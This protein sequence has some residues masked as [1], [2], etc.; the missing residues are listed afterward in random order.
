MLAALRHPSIAPWDLQHAYWGCFV[1]IRWVR[2][3]VIALSC[4]WIPK[5]HNER[6]DPILFFQYY[7]A[8]SILFDGSIRGRINLYGVSLK[9]NAL[10]KHLL[11][12]TLHTN[13]QH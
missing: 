11:M 10:A 4:L 8:D 6:P 2:S 1:R 7:S 5:H 12:C 3:F 9:N 13:D